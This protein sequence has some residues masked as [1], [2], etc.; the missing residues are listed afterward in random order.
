MKKYIVLLSI[1]ILIL[2]TIGYYFLTNITQST[3][4]NETSQQNSE[5]LL[6]TPII[7][8]NQKTETLIP[9][10]TIE[11]AQAQLIKLLS[12]NNGCKL[13]CL[14]GIIPGIS[15]TM[16]TEQLLIPLSPIY[17]FE[18]ITPSPA[19]FEINYSKS[20]T[21]LDLNLIYVYENDIVTHVFFEMDEKRN[22]FTNDGEPTITDVYNSDDF[23]DDIQPY[24]LSSILS[25][26]GIPSSILIQ[27]FNSE[28]SMGRNISGGFEILLLYPEDGLLIKY[29]SQM[30]ID[31][32]IVRGCPS[33]AHI[34]MEL[35][36]SGKDESYTD[37]LS[38]IGWNGIW[39]PPVTKPYW[40]PIEEVTEMSVEGFYQAFK[41]PTSQ[42]IE[43]PTKYWVQPF[44]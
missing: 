7:G 37:N 35:F 43:T 23:N 14:W 10:F 20:D 8:Q 27:T 3:N 30:R 17:E 36:P 22:G 39:P 24:L 34:E 9:T 44:Q 42:C 1:I 33:D 21:F 2:I 25:E 4:V 40:K 26:F 31:G 11:K 28:S 12:T 29:T 32:D 19:T 15:S 38:K 6:F 16:Q 41:E 18:I 13:P 5:E